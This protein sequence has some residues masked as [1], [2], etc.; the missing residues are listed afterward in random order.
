MR[1][2][3][4]HE[5]KMRY[6]FLDVY[7]GLI[8][9]L[10]V[11]GHVVREL[12]LP[13]LQTSG[14]FRFHELLH[15]VTGPGFLF[16]AGITFGIS[17]QH[18]WAEFLTLTTTL[19]RRVRKI[20]LLILIG[21]AL[22]LPFFS[23]QK[24]L[25]SSTGAQWMEL[26]SFD[27]LQCI[28]FT[29]FFAHLMMILV[30][31]EKWFPAFLGA[32]MAGV[33]IAT[34]FLWEADFTLLPAAVAA[35]LH[36]SLG[37]V[38][39]L[40]PYSAF[41]FAGAFASFEFMKFAQTGREHAFMRR[42]VL[43]GVAM[44]AGGAL[45]LAGTNGSGSGVEFWNSD[46]V[47]MLV[48]LGSLFVLLGSAWLIERQLRALSNAVAIRWIVLM[49]IESLFVYILH[50]VLLYGSVLNADVH[51]SASWQGSLGWMPSLGMAF[52]LT[53]ILTAT[54]FLWNRIKTVHPEMF[55]LMIWWMVIVFGYEFLTRAY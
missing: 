10:M 26:Y 37:S 48:K 54:A 45:L 14:L 50:L 51:L 41:L 9:I 7:R 31:R 3:E 52:A 47:I 43:A 13:S 4:P 17:V 36:G 27:V 44:T 12:L 35:A 32:A 2:W 38:Y 25:S 23:L 20:G 29:L 30:R 40:F 34:P 19:L 28:G 49:G 22:H 46:P 42:L 1:S 5:V 39:P 21:Y 33:L 53:G 15:G 6:A 55:R 11:E 18:R 8:V 16:G 24:T